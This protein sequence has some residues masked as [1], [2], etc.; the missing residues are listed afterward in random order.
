MQ[1]YKVTSSS[2]RTTMEAHRS[3]NT[4]VISMMLM[5]RTRNGKLFIPTTANRSPS[6]HLATCSVLHTH[7]QT[8]D[9]LLA[10]HGLDHSERLPRSFVLISTPALFDDFYRYVLICCLDVFENATASEDWLSIEKAVEKLPKDTPYFRLIK[11]FLTYGLK[12]DLT[13][14]DPRQNPR[15]IDQA[16]L[17][18]TNRYHE[19]TLCCPLITA[20][21]LVFLLD[22]LDRPIGLILEKR[23]KTLYREPGKWHLP[24]GFVESFESASQCVARETYEEMN[25]VLEAD[26]VKRQIATLEPSKLEQR[27]INWP[28]IYEVHTKRHPDEF[29]SGPN[30]EVEEVRVFPFTELPSANEIA[31]GEG[32]TIIHL[33]NTIHSRLQNA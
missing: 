13:V 11:H 23:A 18:R 32:K 14:I 30:D 2:V 12:D 8:A 22:S 26:A 24:S 19:T 6:P 27:W 25:L 21:G 31:F 9:F 16:R 4:P 33:V 29:W 5:A 17:D 10:V 7:L 28:H 20:S 15:V 3:F 1:I